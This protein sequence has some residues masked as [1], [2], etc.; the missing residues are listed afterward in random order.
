MLTREQE[1]EALAEVDAAVQYVHV[2]LQS[3]LD[4]L[5]GSPPDKT[6]RAAGLYA[7]LQPMADQASQATP[8]TRRLVADLDG[9]Q[10]Q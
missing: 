1:R 2:G 8:M 3:L 6:V 10:M 5:G 7:L 9:R 4:M